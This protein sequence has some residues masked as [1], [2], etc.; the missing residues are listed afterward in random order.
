MRC[1]ERL[2]T[3]EC[4]VSTSSSFQ[5]SLRFGKVCEHFQ[6]LY[7]EIYKRRLNLLSYA[8]SVFLVERTY[9]KSCVIG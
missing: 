6:H 1:A 5:H 7:N 4:F 8:C 2:L 9:L 3:T